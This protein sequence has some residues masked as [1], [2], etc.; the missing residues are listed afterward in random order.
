MN[1][2]TDFP[3]LVRYA[4]GFLGPDETSAMDQALRD[5]PALQERLDGF[6]QFL[7]YLQSAWLRKQAS[8]WAESQQDF[9]TR[10]NRIVGLLNG[11][12][13]DEE[14]RLARQDIASAPHLEAFYDDLFALRDHFEAADRTDP[15]ETLSRWAET[16]MA[17]KTQPVL[18]PAWALRGED[19]IPLELPVPDEYGFSVKLFVGGFDGRRRIVRG[20]I[21]PKPSHGDEVLGE[22]DGAKVWL[23]PESGKRWLD[24]QVNDEGEF[25]LTKVAPGNYAFE[26]AWPGEFLEVLDVKVPSG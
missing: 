14:V 5:E 19:D 22:L 12:L 17:S 4:L 26:M 13:D 25:E 21:Q 10:L 7:R 18:Q 20:R 16:R 3:Q 15:L 9:E 23:L 8:T 24:A 1:S 11:D 2:R 6:N